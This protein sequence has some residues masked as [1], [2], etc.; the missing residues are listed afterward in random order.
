MVYAL[1]KQTMIPLG[2]HLKAYCLDAKK[3]GWKLKFPEVEPLNFN[4]G[5]SGRGG[6]SEMVGEE[7]TKEGLERA[8][9]QA[10]LEGLS[11]GR[12]G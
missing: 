1:Y 12:A 9:M 8:R 2:V 6:W 5:S 10:Y 3:E 11:A 7:L 4:D